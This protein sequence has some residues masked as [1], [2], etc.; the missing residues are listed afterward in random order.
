MFYINMAKKWPGETPESYKFSQLYREK[1]A[2]IQEMGHS[3]FIEFLNWI[4]DVN[5]WKKKEEWK[6]IVD[7][8]FNKYSDHDIIS[9]FNRFK[10]FKKEKPEWY[11][12]EKI[13]NEV[14]GPLRTEIYG[15]NIVKKFFGWYGNYLK[16]LKKNRLEA[17]RKDMEEVMQERIMETLKEWVKNRYT[18]DDE[19][20]V[21][22]DGDVVPNPKYEH[23]PVDNKEMLEDETNMPK[24]AKRPENK[25]QGQE[26]QDLE[27]SNGEEKEEKKKEKRPRKEPEQLK[28][29]FTYD[30]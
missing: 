15:D 8:I 28:I 13:L 24:L 4:E 22:E 26:N 11:K 9:L 23:I 14:K 10:T 19:N 16:L 2:R 3:D 30:D 6:K 18:G 27:A 1:K 7:Q 17:E 12:Y 21:N 20:I 25:E 29:P 5:E